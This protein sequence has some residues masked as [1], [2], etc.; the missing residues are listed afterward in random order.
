[1]YFICPVLFNFYF[2]LLFICSIRIRKEIVGEEEERRERKNT[3]LK[4]VDVAVPEKEKMA[5]RRRQGITR[6]STFKEEIHY[7]FNDVVENHSSSTPSSS[8]SL[9]A[10]AIRASSALR[11]TS[12]SFDRHRDRSKEFDAYGDGSP[13]N[14]S[15]TGFW[16]VLAR[17]AKAIL[18][19]D[20]PGSQQHH[21]SPKITS[22]SYNTSTQPQQS[23]Q[24]DENMKKGDNRKF[25]KGLN[26]LTTSLNQL[27]DTFEKA[28]EEG[29]TI[30]ENKTADIIQETR[31]L[32]MKRQGNNSE[33]QYQAPYANN[34]WQQPQHHMQMQPTQPQN[35]TNHETQLRASRDVAMAT[36][37][38]AKLLLRELKT[39][40]ADLAFAKERCSQLEEENKILRENRE[41][42]DHRADDDLIRLQLETLLAEKAR[43]ANEN[44]TYARENRFLREIVEYHQLTMQDVVY[45]DEGSEEVT[46]VYPIAGS[47]GVSKML[48]ISPRSS[49]SDSLVPEEDSPTEDPQETK[50]IFPLNK[51][52]KEA[53]DVLGDNEPPTSDLLV[54]VK[55]EPTK[56][57]SESSN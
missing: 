25:R 26:A 33:S 42:G 53:Q 38:K 55:E 4:V 5:Y 28:F 20:D 49:T 18:D 11:E 47:S 1:M 40:K 13:E 37:A 46:E 34:S 17:K 30:V 32:Q 15:T 3:T 48:S 27:G 10:K 39:I 43:L 51:Q 44:S 35:Q 2:Y 56:R 29:R 19:D 52:S 8:P 36:A 7:P 12:F 21:I 24:S 50:E 41:K 54:P 16:G 6:A 22:Q 45:L 14:E 57:P 9:A 31:K 23:E